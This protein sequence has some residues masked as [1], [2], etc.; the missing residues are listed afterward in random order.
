ML[1]LLGLDLYSDS[2]VVVTVVR[3]AGDAPAVLARLQ[4]ELLA[5]RGGASPHLAPLIHAGEADGALFAVRAYV[6]GTTLAERLRDGPLPMAE[7]VA[8]ARDAMLGLQALHDCGLLH[9]ELE[10]ASIILRSDETWCGVLAYTGLSRAARLAELGELPIEA[11]YYTSPEQ[12]GLLPRK[13]DQRSDLYSAGAVLFES[14]CGRPPFDGANVNEVLRRH[15]AGTEPSLRA[16]RADVPPA[17]DEVVRRLL[18]T[19]ADDRYP[20]ATAVAFDLTR[21]LAALERGNEPGIGADPGRLSLAE[22]GEPAFV[23][24]ERERETIHRAVGEARAGRGSLILIEA[25]PGAGRSRLLDELARGEERG[26][27]WVLRGA[28]RYRA[29]Q[30]PHGPLDDVL[31]AVLGRVAVDGPFRDLLRARLSNEARAIATVMPELSAA[32]GFEPAGRAPADSFAGAPATRA[33]ALLLAILGTE[34]RPALVLLD[35]CQ[36]AGELTVGLLEQWPGQAGLAHA[37]G[38]GLHTLIVATFNS[39]E[40]AP[41]H[42]LRSI[43]GAPPSALPVLGRGEVAQLVSSM[44]GTVPA[45]A[46]ELV[47]EMSGGSPFMAAE[48]LRGLVETGGLVPELGGWRVDPEQL[49]DAQSSRRAA[50][51]VSRR[52]D[53]LPASVLGLLSVGAV[54][55]RRFSADLAARLDG[56]SAA[57][58]QAALAEA[59]RGHIVWFDQRT[60]QWSFLHEKLREML[61]ARL[62]EPE[63]QKLHLRAARM[64]EAQDAGQAFELALHLDAAG[65]PVRALPYALEAVARARSRHSLAAAERCYRIAERGADPG[66]KAVQRLVNEG[67][68]DVAMLRGNYAEA[69]AR[70]SAAALACDSDLTRAQVEGKRGS[71]ALRRGDADAAVAT[72]EGAL[73]LL[74][75]RVPRRRSGFWVGLV[76]QILCQLLHTLLPRVFIGRR[77][78]AHAQRDRLA[79][80][81]LSGLARAYWFGSGRVPCLWANLRAMNLIERFPP[82]E[83]LAQAYADHASA[84]TMIPYFARGIAYAERSLAMQREFDDAWGAAQSEQS[85]GVVLYAASRFE[86]ALAHSRSAVRTL[87]PA[88]RPWALSTASWHVALSLYR[89]GR[90]PEAIDAS[91]RVYRAAIERGDLQAAGISLG[92]WAKAADGE[93]PAEPVRDARATLSSDVH[94][95]AEVLAADAVRLLALGEPAAAVHALERADTNVRRSGLHQE[96]VSSV[97]P[98]L[99]TALRMQLATTTELAPRRRRQIARRAR[100]VARRAVRRA[101]RY[102]NNLPHALRELG[103]LAA[104]DGRARRARHLLGRSLR[105]AEQQGAAREYALTLRAHGEL[106]VALGWPQGNAELAR[107]RWLLDP[108]RSESASRGQHEPTLSLADRF[109]TLLEAGRSIASGL[110]REAVFAA[111]HE[112]AIALLRAQQCTVFAVAEAGEGPVLRPVA[113]AAE[114]DDSRAAVAVALRL[115]EPVVPE[116]DLRAA[117]EPQTGRS[118]LCAT[119]LVRGR[120]EACL[121]VSHSGVGGL[122]GEQE[123]QL[124][125]Y[126]VTLAGAALENAQGFAEAQELS[127]SL[128][129]RVHERTAE[130][131]A[132]K[133]EMAATLSLLTATLESTTDGILVVDA[134]GR[135]V[136]HNRKFGDMWRMPPEILA[137]RDDE[138]MVACAI[139]QL[140]DADAFLSKIRELDEDPEAES[141]DLLEFKDGRVFERYSLPQRIDGRCVG[142]VWSFRDVTL[143]KQSERELEHLA[144][145]DGLTGLMSRRRFEQEVE[146]TLS[147]ISRYGGRVAAMILDVD[148]FKYVNDTLGHGAGD[149]LIRSVARLLAGRLRASDVVARLGGDEFAVLLREVDAETAQQVAADVLTAVRHHTAF[150]AGQRISMTVSIGVALLEDEAVDAG[151]LLAD[152]DLAMYDAKRGGRDGVSIYTPERAREARL[153]ARLSWAERLREALE[154]DSFVLYAQPILDLRSGEVTRHEVLLRLPGERGEALAPETFLPSAERLGIGPAIDRWVVTHAIRE[155]GSWTG[156]GRAHSLAINLSGSSIGDPELPDLIAA[157]IQAAGVEPGRVIFEVTET[158]TIANMDEAKRFTAAV[159]ELGCKFALDD[160]GTG[161]GSFYYLKHLPVDYLKID[162]DFVDDP[163]GNEVD[164]LVVNAIVDMARGMG[165]QTIAEHVQSAGMLAQARRLGIDYAQGYHIGLPAPLSELAGSLSESTAH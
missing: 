41:D 102:R 47:Q 11:A 162:G 39:D 77:E 46:G 81:L 20:S 29:V 86:E 147:H 153:E 1:T 137:A 44:A 138:R 42:V 120:P 49:A 87:H 25:D 141:Y 70:L 134:L 95:G 154:N 45:E 51:F 31:A 89:L 71:L 62:S 21:V 136:S 12:A 114:D 112:A 124:A 117:G 90:I 37:A 80:R 53:Q 58:V 14:L 119:V 115:G 83:E 3:P 15:V 142:R 130:L 79:A 55:G 160:F 5:L 106:G 24:R 157:E 48:A 17:L 50:R 10:P 66:D 146:R 60:G 84:M 30:S 88:T 72:L 4:N 163:E 2:D 127:R 28:G 67:L 156:P 158:A 32:L 69:A 68:G 65:D 8:I 96:Y 98:W 92:A 104:A 52:L 18:R 105:V 109:T 150:I 61:L 99:A 54:L 103:L 133:E 100:R 75:V 164:R 63:R 123:R 149:E 122:F 111:V 116:L 132:S 165:K 148:N 26:A 36:W 35:D 23:G 33:F 59:R 159:T 143:Q 125:A 34:E 19:E 129:L 43:P 73:R 108:A 57:E 82:T 38:E 27:V 161:F 64:I 74:R 85:L 144:N 7:A 76:A 6:P 107:A 93:I 40:L 126:V 140:L 22:L 145:H 151:Q 16:I 139:E 9:R 91:R 128:E 13:V 135:I 118:T 101:R 113:G 152:A 110:T 121:Y 94:T 56:R 97:L 131:S 78:L 155:L